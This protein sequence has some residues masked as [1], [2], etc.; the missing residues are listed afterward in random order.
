MKRLVAPLCVFLICLLFLQRSAGQAVITVGRVIG[1]ITTCQGVESVNQEYQSFLLL[2]F[3]LT[4]TV[5]VAAPAGFLAS[6]AQNSGFKGAITLTPKKGAIIDTIYVRLGPMATV[7]NVGGLVAITYNGLAPQTV[8]VTGTVLPMPSAD[9]EPNITVEN[10]TTLPRLNFEGTGNMYNWTSSN[11]NIGLAQSGI[12]SLPT[13]RVLSSSPDTVVDTITVTPVLAGLAYV[14]NNTDNTVSVINTLTNTLDTTISGLPRYPSNEI[15]SP[16]DSELYVLDFN[17]QYISVINTITNKLVK[18]FMIPETPYPA[19]FPYE[20]AVNPEGTRLY[21]VDVGDG[22]LF[23]LDA[24]TGKQILQENTNGLYPSEIIFSNS[25]NLFYIGEDHGIN[26]SIYVFNA[27]SNTQSGQIN[28]PTAFGSPVYGLPPEPYSYINMVSS[29]D[30]TRL[31][32]GGDVVNTVTQ[33]WIT[34]LKT[35]YAGMGVPGAVAIS[36]D[37]K[38]LYVIITGI[39]TQSAIQVFNTTTYAMTASI[40]FVQ[41][42]GTPSGLCINPDGAYLYV[43]MTGTNMLM[44]INTLTNTIVTSIPVGNSPEIN[45][46]CVKPGGCFGD[47]ITFTIT[48][49]PGPVPIIISSTETL[50]ALITTYGTPSASENFTVSGKLLRAGI[51]VTAPRGF[52]V[53]LDNST[54]SS[55]VTINGSGTLPATAVYIRLMAADMVGTYTGHVVL[56]SPGAGNNNILIL[57]STVN[58]ADLTITADNKTKAYRAPNPPLTV[59]YQ[60]FEDGDGPAQLTAPPMISTTAVTDSPVGVYPITVSGA[61]DLNYDFSYIQGTL[62]VLPDV[63]IPNTFTPNGDGIN[64]KWDIQ[65]IDNYPNCNMKVFNRDGQLVYSSTGYSI[66]WDGTYKGSA[67]PAGT[68][69]YILNLNADVPVLSGFVAII[70]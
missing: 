1:Q 20:M 12:D 64:D 46:N 4:S 34:T 67:L 16:N 14:T 57:K 18:N 7:G 25:G 50:P 52:E 44:L 48:V 41:S 33:K 55:T 15:L 54:F 45:A 38:Q 60:G 19:K 26:G 32:T 6:L 21:L 58:P 53:S 42:Q 5:N 8:A 63:V 40:N 28:L 9:P 37:G 23:V 29:P 3:N 69:Y 2:G 51:L 61:Y 49:T 65:K 68:Y 27:G 10:G 22:V 56:T 59:T 30:S 11:P 62:T 39:G 66:P 36:P 17:S 70:R 43:S 47:P 24:L 13:F 35:G 31:Y